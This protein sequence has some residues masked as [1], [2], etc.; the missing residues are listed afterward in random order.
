MNTSTRVVAIIASLPLLAAGCGGSGSPV[1][2]LGSTSTQRNSPSD[3][4]PSSSQ[5]DGPVAFARCMRSHRLPNWPDP[6]RSG[7]FDKSRLTPQKLGAS[8]S[9]IQ[10]A[11]TACQHLLPGRGAPDA[12]RVQQIRAQ[13]LEFSRCVRS[14]GVPNFPDP[15]IDGRIPDPATAGIDQG[16][17]VFEAANQACGKDRPPYMPS[18]SAYN[19]YTTAQG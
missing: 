9:R 4:A 6:N 18:N 14:H 8:S 1:A 13:G 7:A 10:A 12:A 16:S 3:T 5:A 2:Q 17:P 15:A 19:A 11:Q